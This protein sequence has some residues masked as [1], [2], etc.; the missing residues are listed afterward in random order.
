MIIEES[1]FRAEQISD[2]SIFWDLNLLKTKNKRDGSVVEELGDT[3]Y[4][5]PL[6][7]VMKRIVANRI[8][9]R[10]KDGALTMR[11]YL[12][13]WKQEMIKL[14]QLSLNEK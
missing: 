4:G 3:L 1:D 5:L 11:Q 7:S 6:D 2:D 14:S 8:A 12:D 13:E 9:R 10:N